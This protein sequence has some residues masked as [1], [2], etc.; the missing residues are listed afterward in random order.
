MLRLLS[1]M[2]SELQ[3]A[4]TR[5]LSKIVVIDLMKKI[6]IK[7]SYMIPIYKNNTIDKLFKD[8]FEDTTVWDNYK[9]S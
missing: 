2:P 6:N 5:R 1:M 9:Q 4:E 3:N 8:A 7:Y